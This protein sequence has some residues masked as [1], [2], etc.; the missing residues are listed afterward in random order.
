MDVRFIASVSVIAPDPV[1][2]RALYVD[3]LG[4]PLTSMGGD[5]FAS[6]DIAGSKHFGVWPLREAAEACFGT[7]T[8]PADRPVPQVSI[9]FDVDTP[10]AVA[11]SAAELA[12]RGHILLH[13]ART[14]P[15]GQIVAR[16]QSPEG[17]IV[18]ISY[19]PQLH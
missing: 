14:Q 18:G 9:E 2:S 4:L 1:A 5:Y 3:A 17:A 6:E 16:L 19:S 8:W 10:D 15:W 12:E 13:P 11:T 7:D